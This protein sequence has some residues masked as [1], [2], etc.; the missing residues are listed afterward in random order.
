MTGIDLAN[1]TR[2]F[3]VTWE[4]WN[5]GMVM[6]LH[7][8]TLSEY[9]PRNEDEK[10]T[11]PPPWRWDIKKKLKKKI[12]PKLPKIMRNGQKQCRW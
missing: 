6:Y 5:T 9:V 3:S 1:D 4:V 7:Q 2:D 11:E 12:E 8:T 10:V